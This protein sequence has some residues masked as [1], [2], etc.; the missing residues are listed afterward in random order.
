M[1]GP[2]ISLKLLAC[3]GKGAIGIERQLWVLIEATQVFQSLPVDWRLV[4]NNLDLKR[5]LAHLAIL[6]EPISLQA[7][8]QMQCR[9][10]QQVNSAGGVKQQC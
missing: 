5:N 2:R 7:Q 1:A 9:Q 3:E 6:D 4:S 10:E 8:H